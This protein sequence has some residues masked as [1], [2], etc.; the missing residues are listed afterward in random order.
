MI[1]HYLYLLLLMLVAASCE[2]TYAPKPKGYNRMDLPKAEYESLSE[3]H[4]YSFERSV[5]AKE[6]PDVSKIA[7]PHWIEVYYP[8]LKCYVQ[9][10]YKSLAGK[11]NQ[12]IEEHI[13]DSH[14]L[15]NKHNI[16]AYSIDRSFTR[17]KAGYG[18]TYFELTG[19]V[20][21]QFQFYVTD[22][23]K[24]F[25]RG[26]LYF[27]SATKNDSLKPVIDYLKEDMVHMV[28]TMRFEN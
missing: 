23:T 11:K 18:V 22:S 24:H 17:S 20:P 6:R 2:Q 10:T 5:H 28:E 4:P 27:N 25:V 8:D 9:I 13:E 1:K 15:A 16:K 19:E 21:S 14:K 3:K 26:A 12:T 7:E